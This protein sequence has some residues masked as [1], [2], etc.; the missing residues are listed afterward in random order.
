MT[1][2]FGMPLLQEKRNF[3]EGNSAMRADVGWCSDS[4][5]C[6]DPLSHEKNEIDSSSS[7]SALKIGAVGS[8]SDSSLMSN[9]SSE[10]NAN[11]TP[12]LGF[13][14]LFGVRALFCL[15]DLG[16]PPLLWL[17]RRGVLRLLFRSNRLWAKWHWS[18]CLQPLL[19][20][21]NAEHTPGCLYLHFL[22]LHFPLR[23]FR[24]TSF[25]LGL[26]PN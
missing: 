26:P 5:S 24:Q 20:V 2:G 21:K 11:L 3:P 6:S 8:E 25:A 15:L 13:L 4:K 14:V 7:P 19:E 12:A 10:R 17:R 18:P 1:F 22:D 9:V 23:K 16:F